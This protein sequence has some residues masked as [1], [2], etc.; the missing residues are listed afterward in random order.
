MPATSHLGSEAGLVCTSKPPRG[1]LHP[2]SAQLRKAPQT[3]S[4]AT[5]ALA[6]RTLT[7]A[8]RGAQRTHAYPCKDSHA[9]LRRLQRA[10]PG[11]GVKPFPGE[12]PPLQEVRHSGKRKEA[13]GCLRVLC[14]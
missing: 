7:R 9:E 12:S 8:S 6:R 13:L 4:T 10:L 14:W 5:G 2:R 3:V 1:V 11:C